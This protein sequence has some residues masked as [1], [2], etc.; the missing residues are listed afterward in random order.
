[1]TSQNSIMGLK[2]TEPFLTLLEQRGIRDL[3]TLA[4]FLSSPLPEMVLLLGLDQSTAHRMN[5]L[6]LLVLLQYRFFDPD[7]HTSTFEA[8][9]FHL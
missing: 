5:L 9:V 8:M 2:I 4:A 3:T 7:A 6:Q 1:M